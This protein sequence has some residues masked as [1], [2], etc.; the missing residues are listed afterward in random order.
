MRKI[1]VVGLV[2]ASLGLASCGVQASLN[3]AVTSLGATANLQVHLTGSASGPGT[4]EAQ[5]VLQDVSID[6]SYTNPS[7]AALSSSNAKVNAEVVFN[8]SGQSVLD[9]RG[10]DDNAYVMVNLSPLSS[11]PGVN[12][13]SSEMS[14]LQLVLGGRWFELPKSLIASEIPSTSTLKTNSAKDQATVTKLIDAISGV[15]SAT[16]YTTLPGGGYTETGTLESLVTALLPTIKGLDSGTLNAPSDVPGTYGLTITTSGSTATGGSIA[17][18]A[19]NG[20][21]GNDTVTLNATVAHASNA[22]TAP[23]G[24]TIITSSM[25]KGLLSQANLTIPTMSIPKGSAVYGTTQ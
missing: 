13:P 25:L 9:I 10:V 16:K 6:M 17:I 4:T 18:T 14:A 11:L 7:G 19:P 3:Q 2:V 23:I 5:N 21:K 20:T 15:I 12:L 22:V 8:V 24:A 1:L